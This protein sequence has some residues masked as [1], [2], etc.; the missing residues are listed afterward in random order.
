MLNGLALLVVSPGA[1]MC[2]LEDRLHPGGEA[3]FWFWTHVLAVL[4]GLPG[5]YLRRAFYSLT[6]RSCSLNSWIDFGVLFAHRTARVEQ[7]VYVGAYTVVGS[8]RLRRGCL[9]GTRASLLS[10]SAQHERRE[11]GR[12]GSTDAAR[13]QEIEIGEHAWIGEAAI[14][15]ADVGAGAQVAAGAVVLAAVPPGIV[16]A[17]NPARFVRDTGQAASS[18]R[19]SQ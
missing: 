1:L 19:R 15:M 8:A 4:P 10:G 5:L 2:W 12:W 11:D 7:E 6:L 3:V 17:G 18:Q 9:I 14:V 16:V 13:L